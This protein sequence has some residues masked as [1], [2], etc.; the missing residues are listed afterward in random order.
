MP[1]CHSV[2]EIIINVWRGLFRRDVSGEIVWEVE[3][4]SVICLAV[5]MS[6]GKLSRGGNPWGELSDRNVRGGNV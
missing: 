6:R 3:M 2:S 5:E 4:S 1:G